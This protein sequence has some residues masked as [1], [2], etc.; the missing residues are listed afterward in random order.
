MEAK[1]RGREGERERRHDKEARDEGHR[2]A[3]A[4][5]GGRGGGGEGRGSCVGE[6]EIGTIGKEKGRRE[7]CV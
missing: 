6:G 3:A 1:D 4:H 5:G 2:D 7:G